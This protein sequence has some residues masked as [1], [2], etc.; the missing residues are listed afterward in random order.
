[1]INILIL[2]VSLFDGMAPSKRVFNLLEPLVDPKL[3]EIYNLIYSVD[4]KFKH[5]ESGM[6]N[7]INF[8]NIK[9]KFVNLFSFFY[10]GFK[11]LHTVNRFKNSNRILYN[12]GYLDLKN[13]LFVLYARILGFKIVIDIVEDNKYHTW[14][15]G[16]LGYFRI[17][18]SLL[19][20]KLI[21]FITHA[22]I[23]ISSQLEKKFSYLKQNK[24]ICIIPITVS[25]EKFPKNVI[26][27]DFKHKINLFYGGSFGEK[28]GVTYL[29]Q[30]FEILADE[31]PK[32]NLILTG[33]PHNKEANDWLN[34]VL[35][36]SKNSDRIFYYGMLS[37]DTYYSILN[38]C[39]IF[40]MTRN[41]SQ[42][43]NSG[44]PFKLGEYLATGKGVV[45]SNVG[46]VSSYLTNNFDS[47]LVQPESIPEIVN[48]ISFLISNPE[49]IKI[50]GENAR[51]TAINNFSSIK[52]S[53]K[54]YNFLN[55][56]I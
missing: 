30:A 11:Y 40:C 55:E 51:N 35:K 31:F 49:K 9:F 8:F 53:K 17:K 45:A 46:D 47:I 43:A 10:L 7:N 38:S 15:N 28:D 36:K 54:F 27:N 41:N 33:K 29:L 32:L 5:G 34:S 1:M 44:F 2:N 6:I 25:M 16:I 56:L 37:I 48:A 23:V 12:Y 21:P 18:S 26:I 20:V 42:F 50:L 4:S 14:H 52:L 22:I 13:I 19:F 24:K 39:D 3:I